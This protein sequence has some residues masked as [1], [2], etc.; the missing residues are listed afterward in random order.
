[1]THAKA[2]LVTTDLS[3]NSRAGL[4]LASALARREQ[5]N[6]HV[7]CI[8]ETPPVGAEAPTDIEGYLLSRKAREREFRQLVA[9]L[10][11]AESISVV[12]HFLEGP[13]VDKILEVIKEI[14]PVF[15]IMATHGRSGLSRLLL[16]SVTESVLRQSPA[17]VLCVK[18]NATSLQAGPVLVSTDLSAHAAEALPIAAALARESASALHLVMA[19][20][21]QLHVQDGIPPQTPLTWMVEEHRRMERHL[22]RIAAQVKSTH[23]LEVT[24]HLRHGRAAEEILTQAAELKA[25]LIVMTSHGRSGIKRLLVG[26]VTEEVIRRSACPVL[27]IRASEEVAA[28]AGSAVA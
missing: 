11:H 14:K 15:V 22:H 9:D 13:V 7:V 25:G 26:S 12:P 16:G 24:T 4:P 1:M 8:E 6:L 20:E 3:Q 18:S 28:K 19:L 5:A 17:P 23:G 10:M 2:V 27:V 21:D